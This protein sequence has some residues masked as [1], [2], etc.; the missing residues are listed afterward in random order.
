MAGGKPVVLEERA[1][2]GRGP[3][4]KSESVKIRFDQFVRHLLDDPDRFSGT[5]AKLRMATRIEK[6]IEPKDGKE[7][8]AGGEVVV[9]GEDDWKV[10]REVAMEP[11]HGYPVMIFGQQQIPAGRVCVPF[12]DALEDPPN[13]HPTV[14]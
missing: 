3:V 8:L 7:L 10:L 4:V 1:D 12:I 2:G 14:N 13:R 6:A 5:A 11:K 9:L